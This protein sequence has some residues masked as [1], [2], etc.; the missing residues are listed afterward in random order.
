MSSKAELILGRAVDLACEGWYIYAKDG[1]FTY[2]MHA[3][4]GRYLFYKVINGKGI[5]LMG[6]YLRDDELERA[7]NSGSLKVYKSNRPSTKHRDHWVE[8]VAKEPEKE[9]PNDIHFSYQG[10]GSNMSADLLEQ[11]LHWI[12]DPATVKGSKFIITYDS[13]R[14]SPRL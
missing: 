13:S 10:D 12:A 4:E 11:L 1:V 3:V 2:S 5:A 14:E 6:N 7:I 8:I 9:S